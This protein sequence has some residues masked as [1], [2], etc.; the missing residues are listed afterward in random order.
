M[1]EGGEG[2][3][4]G[5][6]GEGASGSYSGEGS[7]SQGWD[8]SSVFDEAGRFKEDFG[9]SMASDNLPADFLNRFQGKTPSEVFSS[10]RDNMTSA[11]A[12]AVTYPG[13]ESTDEDRANWNRAA[14]VPEEVA[15]VLPQ[16]MKGFTE[17][18]GWT[19]EVVTPAIQ[20]MI[21]AGTPGPAITAATQ[22]VQAAAEVQMSAYHAEAEK[23]SQEG[24]DAFIAQHGAKHEQALEGAKTAVEKLALKAGLPAESIA[25]LSENVGDFVNPELTSMMA[26]LSDTISEAQFR[27][28]G[29][30]NM[31]DEFGGPERELASY[32]EDSGHPNRERFLKGD[33]AANDRVNELIELTRKK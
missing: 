27:G 24:K 11:R 23:I 7:Q 10:L 26:V 22:A 8:S 17:A 19:E 1:D 2:A 33:T 18:T 15:Q 25:R 3:S 32:L 16:D 14:G 28:A 4:G 21:D 9:S 20:A 5:G 30:S 12:K 13:S 31:G 6:A 29:A